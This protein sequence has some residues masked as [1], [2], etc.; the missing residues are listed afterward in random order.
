MQVCLPRAP[1]PE[2][3]EDPGAVRKKVYL[4]TFPH[5]VRSHTRTGVALRSPEVLSKRESLH[6]V[7]A[8]CTHPVYRDAHSN[9]ASFA[10]KV[11]QAGGVAGVPPRWGGRRCAHT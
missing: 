4:V 10:V 3:C 11:V 2:A 6:A 7:M 8:A 5:P 1:E 9:S